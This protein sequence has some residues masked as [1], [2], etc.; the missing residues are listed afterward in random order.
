M[1]DTNTATIL[2]SFWFTYPLL[3]VLQYHLDYHA[4]LDN[5]YNCSSSW[6]FNFQ[7]FLYRYKNI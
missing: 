7:P 5:T 1:I 4:I 2:K 3:C 6:H